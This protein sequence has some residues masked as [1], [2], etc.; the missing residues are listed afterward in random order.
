[1]DRKARRSPTNSDQYARVGHFM[2]RLRDHVENNQT[3]GSSPRVFHLVQKVRRSTAQVRPPRAA[4]TFRVLG[5]DD[6]G[7]LRNPQ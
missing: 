7:R 2:Y 1:M 4:T 3:G 6:G 5:P